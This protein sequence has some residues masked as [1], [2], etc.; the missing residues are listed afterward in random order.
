[1]NKALEGSS[2]D[3]ASG[4]IRVLKCRLCSS[5]DFSNWEDFKRHGKY[6]EV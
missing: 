3:W 1:V 5:A 2:K 6:M 4:T